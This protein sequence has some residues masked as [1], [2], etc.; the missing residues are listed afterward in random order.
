MRVL[1]ILGRMGA[2]LAVLAALAMAGPACAPQPP[3]TPSWD[4]D[5]FPILRGNCLH[6]HGET[7]ETT[8]Q[9][10]SW[11]FD[12]CSAT[13]PGFA[14][15]GVAPATDVVLHLDHILGVVRSRTADR[16][17]MPP[18]P[19]FPLFDYEVTVLKNWASQGRDRA[20][21]CRKVGPNQPPQAKLV[22][23]A[24]GPAGWELDVD[25]VD[26]DREQIFGR[27]TGITPPATILSA[28]R[29]RFH[30]PGGAPVPLTLVLTDGYDVTT[31]T[32]P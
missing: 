10:L 27:A 23:S 18:A 8:A 5:V 13:L 21:L 17:V 31:V 6:C 24:P 7:A 2:G 30:L 14:E 29:R 11:R 4:Q 3:A 1:A 20:V 12:V 9:L 26:P 25:L 28:G 32:L 15:V 22:R 16:P 19:A